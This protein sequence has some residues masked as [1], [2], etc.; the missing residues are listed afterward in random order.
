MATDKADRAQEEDEEDD[1]N[2]SDL[3]VSYHSQLDLAEDLNI[4]RTWR[5]P[6]TDTL[7]E[8]RSPG[9]P[10]ASNLCY[11]V[12]L[13]SL[14]LAQDAFLCSLLSLGDTYHGTQATHNVKEVS[15]ITI[16]LFP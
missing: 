5:Y 12:P 2:W 8:L 7:M 4:L 14:L 15:K 13:R 9:M 6:R 10:S 16:P 3:E 1:E 11:C